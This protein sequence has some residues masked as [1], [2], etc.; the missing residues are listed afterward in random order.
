MWSL[1]I[2]PAAAIIYESIHSGALNGRVDSDGAVPPCNLAMMHAG[3]AGARRRARARDV[4][5]DGQ[6]ARPALHV[7]KR[8]FDFRD[9]RERPTQPYSKAWRDQ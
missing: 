9:G 8:S 1:P 3:L 2:I 7:R 5:D 6:R 4:R